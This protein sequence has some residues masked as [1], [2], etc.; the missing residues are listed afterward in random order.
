MTPPQQP[1]CKGTDKK[2]ELVWG[3]IPMPRWQ[4][5]MFPVRYVG[6]F[7]AFW[8]KQQL[9]ERRGYEGDRNAPSMVLKADSSRLNK[10]RK[11]HSGD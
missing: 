5:V 7:L 4:Q 6:D 2:G 9:F 3:F 8:L 1:I 11:H 10:S